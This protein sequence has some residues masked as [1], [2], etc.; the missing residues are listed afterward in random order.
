MNDIFKLFKKSIET[1]SVKKTKQGTFTS[2][3][4]Y[5]VDL[6]AIVKRRSGTANGSNDDDQYKNSSTI[7]FMPKDAANVELGNFVKYDGLWREITFIKDGKN[8]DTGKTEFLWVTVGDEII[9]SPDSPNWGG[10]A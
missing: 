5:N 4:V 8:F 10:S 1:V 6:Q 3:T 7:H 2:T 9:E